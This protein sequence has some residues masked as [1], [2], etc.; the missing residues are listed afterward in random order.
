M[1]S[2]VTR[3]AIDLY[4]L[5]KACASPFG[6]F[7]EVLFGT[8]GHVAVHELGNAPARYAVDGKVAHTLDDLSFPLPS[9]VEDGRFDN[10][11]LDAPSA[12]R[13]RTKEDDEREIEFLTLRFC[14][15]LNRKVL[16]LSR[17]CFES[18]VVIPGRIS[19]LTDIPD[20]ETALVDGEESAIRQV[21]V[22]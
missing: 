10:I 22:T 11:H 14:G 19:V 1:A 17:T 7:A 16:N 21:H 5:V 18:K 12:F 2:P 15:D 20:V 8:T 6:I 4:A 13:Y 9:D 3:P